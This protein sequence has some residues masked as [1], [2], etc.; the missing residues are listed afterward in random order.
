M[1]DE[2]NAVDKHIGARLRT[3]RIMLDLTQLQI[4]E[5]LGVTFQQVQKYEKGE[6]RIGAGRLQRLCHRLRVPVSFFFEGLGGS[7]PFGG[8]TIFEVRAPVRLVE[9]NAARLYAPL[10]SRSVA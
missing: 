7:R 2:I 8:S 10:I 9:R 4:A 5:A 3:R 1:V 6:G